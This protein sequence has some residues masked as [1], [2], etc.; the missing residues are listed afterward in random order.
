M[1]TPPARR[2]LMTTDAVGGVWTYATDL[3]C[4]LCERGDEVTLVVMGPAPRT[5]QLAPL[6]DI[7]GLSIEP[8]DLA[9]EWMDPDGSDIANARD[10][11]LSIARR[12]RP[13]I[14]HLNS[15]REAVFDWPAPVLVVAHS[16]VW[17]WWQDCRGGAPDDPRWHRYAESVAAGLAAAD[18]WCAPSEAFRSMIKALYPVRTPGRVIHNGA[19]LQAAF[20]DKQPLILAAGRLWDEGKNLSALA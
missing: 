8:T 15:Y 12:V 16:C 6:R 4:G 5:E 10:H 17:S 13:D 3:S 9:L 1:M 18:M 19:S 7:R 11:L 2:I 14:I 20:H